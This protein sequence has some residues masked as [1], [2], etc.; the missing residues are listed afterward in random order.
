M[1]AD[2]LEQEFYWAQWAKIICSF[3]FG[4]ENTKYFQIAATIQKNEKVIW[5]IMDDNGLLFKD[6]NDIFHVFT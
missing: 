2:A 3:L 5:K 4:D 1:Q 6:Q